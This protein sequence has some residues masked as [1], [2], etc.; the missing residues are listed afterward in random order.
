[1]TIEIGANL[2]GL[3]YELAWWAWWAYVITLGMRM[4]STLVHRPKAGR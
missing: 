2:K 4:V 3:L 1:M